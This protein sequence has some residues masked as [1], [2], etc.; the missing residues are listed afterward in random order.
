MPLAQSAGN[1]APDTLSDQVV[2]GGRP[3]RDEPVE[4]TILKAC[5]EGRS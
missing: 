2:M 1:T 4:E 3:P 5:Q